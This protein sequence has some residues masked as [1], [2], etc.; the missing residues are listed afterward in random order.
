MRVY[1]QI[2]A[3]DGKPPR[4]YQLALQQD[5]LSGWNLIREWG[6]QGQA[7][8]IKRDHFP[9]RES[10]LDALLRVRDIQIKRG[11]QVVFLKGMDKPGP[12]GP[13]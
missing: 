4:F 11:Y 3:L 9:D 12:A 8:R 13:P 6:Q 10:A 2:P 5:L 7:G 1:M